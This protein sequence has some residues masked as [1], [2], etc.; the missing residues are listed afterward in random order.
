MMGKCL[1][2]VTCLTG[3]FL[4]VFSPPAF[5]AEPFENKTL[6]PY[7]FIDNGD[8]GIDQFPLKD[9]HVEVT[10]SGVIAEVTVKQTYTN[11][12]S[13]P[14]NANYV[15]PAS[16][17]AAVHGMTMII[18]EL[19]IK[20]EIRER[21]QARR[22]FEKAKQAG[23]SASLLEQQRPNVFSMHVANV[24]PG[25]RIRVELRYTEL[26]VP[27]EGTYEFVYPT[28]VGPRYSSQ[29]EATAPQTDMWV[30]S[31]YL[32]KGESPRY[33]FTI[34]G[35][36]STG[37]PLKELACPSHEIQANWE[38]ESRLKFSLA[39]SVDGAGNRDFI[40]KYRLAG[41]QIE[42]GLLLQ[43]GSVENFFLLM[44][45]PPRSI[46]PKI[47]PL[48]EYVFVVDVSGSMNG[49]PL[50]TA[51]ELLRDLIDHLNPRDMFNV[52]LFAGGSHIL[53]PRSLPAT[54]GNISSAIDF[55]NRQRGGGGTELQSALRRAMALPHEEGLSRNFV[56]VTDGYIIA[57]KN[58]FQYIQAHL[59]EAN[60]FA[61]G[62]GSSVNR[63]LIEGVA[64]AGMGEPFVVT[65]PVEAPEA[66][67]RFRQYIQ[68]PVLT[69]IKVQ[70]D[71][72]KVFDVEPVSVPD[73]LAQRP[74]I[75]HGKWAGKSEGTIIVSGVSGS[76][77][78]TR[79]FDVSRTAPS[80]SNRAIR[81]LWARTRI[82]K[83]SDFSR[84]AETEDEKAEIT[85]L[86]LTYNLLT[87]YT[88][89]VA[90]CEVVRNGNT[91]AKNVKQPL[92]LP[93]GV[94]NLAVGQPVTSG[95]EPELA[96]LLVLCA[97]LLAA[98]WLARTRRTS[99]SR[100]A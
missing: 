92:P 64:K 43:R 14:I 97:L 11:E 45:Q 80:E 62:I 50:N 22:E 49:F 63:F 9:T 88:S 32:K 25:D 93:R 38:N 1:R 59:G 20:A 98:A 58:V 72:F 40:L 57:E 24:M 77:H 51:K 31:P 47:I 23:Q 13:R 46:T 41:D 54:S 61:F 83:L 19:V 90:V 42:S 55:I 76:G 33:A 34:H 18:G 7:F 96:L 17:R 95:P 35:T 67:S 48:R 16:T 73:V 5:S 37:I 21:A 27:T 6:S 70:Y 99:N 87:K 71:K 100:R 36:L 82:A 81:Y 52:V 15:F 75:I 4:A 68:S 85:S 2:L 30:K 28:V 8:P 53:S 78:Y 94:G 56:V 26:L 86:G 29:P 12:G 89:F 91:P 74:I 10:I 65:T 3:F 39:E 44:V 79:S 60:V 66:A 69:D 84:G